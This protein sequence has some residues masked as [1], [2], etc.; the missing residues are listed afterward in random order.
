MR[1]VLVIGNYFSVV[2][3]LL[4]VF[5]KVNAATLQWWDS[6]YLYRFN[7]NVSTGAN[8]PDKG[9][10]DYTVRIPVLN[11]STLIANGQMQSDCDDLR[12]LFFDGANYQELERHVINCNSASTD[13]RFALFANIA[14]SNND[15][16]YYL[17][18]GNASAGS[19]VVVDPTN[20]YLWY[21]DAS[22]NRSASYVRGRVD[23]WHGTGWD[24]SLTHNALG[25]YTYDTGDNFTSG[26]RRAIDERDVYIE[27]EFFH[28]GCY[29]L[30]QTTGVLTR[31]IIASGSGGAETSLHYYTSN[32]GQ[33]PGCSVAG[34][35]HD[36]DIMKNQRNNIAVN[37]ANPGSITANQWRRQGLASWLINPTNLSFWDEDNSTNW[38]A[39]GYP[40]VANLQINGTD[41]AGGDHEGRGF[42]AIMT[43][44]DISRLRNILIRRYVEPE[45][46]LSLTLDL[47][48][49][50]VISKS[51]LSTT[52]TPGGVTSYTITV[53]NNGPSPVSSATIEDDLPNG[54]TMT[55]PW[56][57]TPSSP[58][59]MCNTAP[60]TT[61]PI[62]IDVDIV[63]G[64][65]ITVT[66]PVSFSSDMTDY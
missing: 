58:G 20:V 35:T 27:A 53:T 26:Y 2:I 52:Y 31:G 41:A 24:N 21:D 10:V 12:I 49:D 60:S 42:A 61:D 66:V 6:N 19:P 64:D 63:N 11:T 44:Q 32:R 39:L 56:T 15:D 65:S 62:S 47:Q 33:Y 57:C 28:T 13:I 3:C 30:N 38:A 59:S 1:L 22:V 25:F 40:S 4:L 16:N 8:T 55:A 14:A 23:P 54:V 45:P 51:D 50:L 5:S 37:G 48:S 46:S 9:Y 34:Y 18:Y 7:I 43:A 29:Q 17:Y 36:G